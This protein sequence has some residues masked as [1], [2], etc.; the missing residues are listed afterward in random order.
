MLALG[1]LADAELP[2]ALTAA[3]TA[4]AVLSLTA[5]AAASC[6]SA[7]RFA[8]RSEVLGPASLERG[9]RGDRGD[10]RVGVVES[11]ELI[12]GRLEPPSSICF[13]PKQK[14]DIRANVTCNLFLN[15]ILKQLVV[16]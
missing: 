1:I 16:N 5:A 10:D 15:T 13:L 8:R 14:P 11:L 4:A 2:S 6:R 9:D 12:R 7:S 3:T